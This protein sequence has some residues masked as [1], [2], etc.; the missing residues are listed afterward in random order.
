L[1]KQRA[2]G[3]SAREIAEIC[4]LSAKRV[5]EILAGVDY[6]QTRRDATAHEAVSR[7]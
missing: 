6:R 5:N 2:A 1:R 4:D 3:L 7:R